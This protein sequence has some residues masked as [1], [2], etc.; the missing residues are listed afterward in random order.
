VRIPPV[1]AVTSLLWLCVCAADGGAGGQ[2]A[3]SPPD[4]QSAQVKSGTGFFVSP[5]NYLLTSRHVVAGCRGIAVWPPNGIEHGARVVAEDEQ[6]DIALLSVRG[7]DAGLQVSHYRDG[8]ELGDTVLTIGY[9]IYPTQPRKAVL[10]QGTFVRR[11]VSPAGARIMIILATLR[12]GNSGGPV[13]DRSGALAGMVIGRFAEHSNLAVIIP[14]RAIERF[15]SLTGLSDLS[16]GSDGSRSGDPN[17]VIAHI[18]AL[19]QCTNK[20]G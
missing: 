18:S 19:V 14:G 10:T 11:D 9:G 20:A 1:I 4:P 5:G 7:G 6:L 13:I 16:G 3:A 17:K 12:P 2:S 15:L 8:L